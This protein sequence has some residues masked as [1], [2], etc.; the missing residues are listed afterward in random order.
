M[1]INTI[2]SIVFFC[3]VIVNYAKYN[4]TM[5]NTKNTIPKILKYPPFLK[6]LEWI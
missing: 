6:Q 5:Q 2:N 1:Q 4:E 3:C